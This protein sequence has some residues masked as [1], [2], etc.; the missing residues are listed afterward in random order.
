MAAYRSWQQRREIIIAMIAEMS[1]K[2]L[3]S[4]N[5]SQSEEIF[6][7]ARAWKAVDALA[8]KTSAFKSYYNMP[9]ARPFL[10][11]V[12]AS[13]IM[14]AVIL[15]CAAVADAF[16]APDKDRTPIATASGALIVA[17]AGWVVAGYMTN[18]N[19]IRQNTN[20]MLFARF[21]QAPFG[22][23]VY[24]FHRKFGFDETIGLTKPE[25]D[26]LRTSDDDD[27]WKA[28]SSVNY[29]L[30]YFE[31]IANG[32]LKGDLDHRIARENFRGVICF[33]HDKCWPYI[34]ALNQGSPRTYENLIRIRTHYREP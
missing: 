30:N 32:V 16:L 2:P 19:T 1:P 3:S 26:A 25:L 11:V 7:R 27:D 18:R 28:A 6:F 31:F 34:R 4:F 22:D 20:T 13:A 15:V 29:L 8:Q 23:A 24:R 10:R 5:L 17:A 9:V 14:I 12:F 33:Y 21:S